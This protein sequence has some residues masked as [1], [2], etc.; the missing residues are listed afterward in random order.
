MHS[1]SC[2]R[3]Y[4]EV[5][6]HRRFQAPWK[7][8]SMLLRYRL[9][10]E[11]QG[12]N[13]GVSFLLM[14]AKEYCQFLMVSQKNYTCTNF[15]DHHDS[16]SHDRI[17]RY[18]K[19]A[20]LSPRMIWEKAEG[21]VVPHLNAYLLFDD[22]VVDKDFSHSIELVRKQYSGNAHSIIKGIGVVTCVYVNPEL[23]RY[24]IIDMRIFA[25]ENDGKSKLD[26][27]KDMLLHTVYAK[28]ISF[29]TVL[30][31][32]WYATRDLILDIEQQGK[33]YY[34]PLKKNRKVDD[35]EGKKPYRQI[36]ELAWTEE[37]DINGKRIKIHSFPKDH[38]V[39]LFR[40]P[41][42]TNRTEYVITNDNTCKTSDDARNACAIR[43]KIEQLHREGKQLTG[44]EKC[45]CRKARIQRNH[46]LCSWLAWLEL[47]KQAYRKGVSLYRLKDSLLDAYLTSELRNP[48]LVF[49]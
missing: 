29:R 16:L 19:D 31:D 17:N 9:A 1:S 38:K 13:T 22:T 32:S 25:P 5:R 6:S 24:W 26:H 33:T 10:K 7:A 44:I 45:Q 30:M 14:N 8:I 42:S 2:G 21:D 41:V 11:N 28:N 48:S 34:C 20:K 49:A 23:N 39:R 35:S 18:L 37:E 12:Y 15:A 43:W 36:A 47:A 4:F 40:V 27:V 3:G 46:I